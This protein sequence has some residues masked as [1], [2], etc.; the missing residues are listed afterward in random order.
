MALQ[1]EGPPLPQPHRACPGQQQ[2]EQEAL[3]PGSGLWAGRG[4]QTGGP[5]GVQGAP[6]LHPVRSS[7]WARKQ[8]ASRQVP[9]RS[10]SPVRYGM[11]WSSGSRARRPPA[12]DRPSARCSRI[13]TCAGRGR[14]MAT[15]EG[16]RA[17]RTECKG[18]CCVPGPIPALAP[19]G[20]AHLHPEPQASSPLRL[21]GPV[22]QCPVWSGLRP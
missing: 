5:G 19:L 10:P 22:L 7:P 18:T 13:V 8:S 1:V 20:Q 2:H 6:G 4:L 3:A 21:L 15:W 17:S 12:G 14:V 16:P 11:Q 9:S